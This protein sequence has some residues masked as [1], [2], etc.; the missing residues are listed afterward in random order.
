MFGPKWSCAVGGLAD[1][2]NWLWPCFVFWAGGQDL[3]QQGQL[4]GGLDPVP[5][6][7][8][9]PHR[10]L[11]PRPTA[12]NGGRRH[13][14]PIVIRGTPIAAMITNGSAGSISR[15]QDRLAGSRQAVPVP[16]GWGG[17]AHAR[18]LRLGVGVFTAVGSLAGTPGFR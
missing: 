8:G 13:L 7:G 14:A 10:P 16:R 1:G 2:R 12:S 4:A 18:T 3:A 9:Q 15:A 5:G 6:G 11:P 17:V